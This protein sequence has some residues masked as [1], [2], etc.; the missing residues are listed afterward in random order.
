MGLVMPSFVQMSVLFRWWECKVLNHFQIYV[1][2]DGIDV[3]NYSFPLYGLINNA[4]T[5]SLNR[6]SSYV[7]MSGYLGRNE[8]YKI[9]VIMY[10]LH[11]TITYIISSLSLSTLH[12]KNVKFGMYFFG[13]IPQNMYI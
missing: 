6:L 13:F 7:R 2:L 11:W 4:L 10:W 5:F 8:F 9:I 3:P 12:Q 1:L